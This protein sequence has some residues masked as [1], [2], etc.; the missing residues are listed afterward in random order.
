MIT[1]IVGIAIGATTTLFLVWFTA[2]LA[3]AARR[4]EARRQAEVDQQAKDFGD[5]PSTTYWYLDQ[6]ISRRDYRALGGR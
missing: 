1:L 5:T 2:E 6:P 4:V 3:V